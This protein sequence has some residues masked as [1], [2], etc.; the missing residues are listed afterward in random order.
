MHLIQAD[1]VDTV[2]AYLNKPGVSFET[3]PT[4]PGDIIQ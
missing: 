3:V 2:L 1:P 4:D